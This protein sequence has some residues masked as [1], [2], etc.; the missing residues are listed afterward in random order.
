M[1][2]DP[3]SQKPVSSILTTLGCSIAIFASSWNRCLKRG[4]D[5]SGN[6][7]TAAG[8]FELSARYTTPMPPEPISSSSANE[9]AC[10]RVGTVR[11]GTPPAISVY[12]LDISSVDTVQTGAYTLSVTGPVPAVS[13]PV[14]LPFAGPLERTP[15]RVTRGKTTPN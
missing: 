3:S 15:A 14:V 5:V 10:V 7:F 1:Y 6:T 8:P 4:D 2:G 11:C 13:E 12:R 9:P